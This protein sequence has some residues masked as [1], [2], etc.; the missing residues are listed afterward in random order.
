MGPRTRSCGS[1][2]LEQTR[3]CSRTR[4]RKSLGLGSRRKRQQRR[5]SSRMEQLTR[6]LARRRQ[7]P[8]SWTQH[9]TGRRQRLP[10]GQRERRF[11]A[12]LSLTKRKFDASERKTCKDGRPILCSTHQVHPQLSGAQHVDHRQHE[13]MVRFCRMLKK[14]SNCVVDRQI[15]TNIPRVVPRHPQIQRFCTPIA[16]FG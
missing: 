8:K 10:K 2:R 9:R 12:W 13:G 16:S 4:E 3:S 1:R 6:S 7:Q 5:K 14:L 15:C 11:E